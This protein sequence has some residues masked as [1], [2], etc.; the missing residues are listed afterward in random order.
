MCGKIAIA[1]LWLNPPPPSPS[2]SSPHK[3]KMHR[4]YVSM[5]TQLWGALFFYLILFFLLLL[6]PPLP[7]PPGGYRTLTHRSKDLAHSNRH[8]AKKEGR[9]LSPSSLI[10]FYTS[11]VCVSP[12]SVR[13]S[14]RTGFCYRTHKVFVIELNLLKSFCYFRRRKKPLNC[15]SSFAGN[16][17]S[18]LLSARDVY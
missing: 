4:L 18:R 9:G 12:L 16:R 13:Y 3:M 10:S 17:F 5:Y 6:L 11:I 8:V 14:I 2:L 15:S 1:C 7:L